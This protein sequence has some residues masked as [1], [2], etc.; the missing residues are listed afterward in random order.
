MDIALY[1]ARKVLVFAGQIAVLAIWAFIGLYLL[2]L[3]LR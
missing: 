2:A 3:L 1:V